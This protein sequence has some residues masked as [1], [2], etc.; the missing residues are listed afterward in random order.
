MRVSFPML[1]CLCLIGC[2]E[3][4]WD[5]VSQQDIPSQDGR[6][7]A[8][9]FEMCSYDTT[10]YWPQIS[11]R[12]PGQGLGSTG[13]ALS[14]GPGDRFTARWVSPRNLEVEYST[15]SERQPYPPST[16]NIHGITVAFKKL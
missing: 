6:Y 2:S 8:T 4:N 10:G 11:L 1:L 15:D 12:R 5:K 9:V 3:S 7:V 16:T 13:N 14:G